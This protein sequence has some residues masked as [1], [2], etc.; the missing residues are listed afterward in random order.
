MLK[1]YR[2]QC[3]NAVFFRNSICLI[4]KSP[5]GFDAT[6][7]LL[8]PLKRSIR[9][10]NSEIW[11]Q[12]GEVDTAENLLDKQYRRCANLQTP[13]ACNWLL[14]S[15][16]PD[17]KIYCLACSLNRTIPD[18]TDASHPENS[19]YWGRVELAKRRMLAGLMGLGLT[20]T[21]KVDDPVGGLAFDLVNTQPGANPV[22]TG[23]DNGLITLNLQEADDAFRESIRTSM[24]EPYRTLLG[25]FRH[26]IGHYF[27]DVLIKNSAW[28]SKFRLLFGDESQDYTSSLQNNYAFGPPKD[29]FLNHVSSYA[30]SHPWEDWAETW[31]HYL[32]MCDT[33]DTA[34]SLGLAVNTQLL[35]FT[36]FKL[37]ALYDTQEENSDTFLVFINEWAGLTVLLN[38]MNR[39]MGQ[40]DFYPF[41]LPDTVVTKLHFIHLV[42]RSANE[43]LNKNSEIM[44]LESI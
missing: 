23:H 37:D 4:C 38:E 32:H 1:R 11:E 30:S 10:L 25:H 16:E 5:L 29:W 15:T 13:A 28:L 12:F 20:I 35:E 26:E 24:G 33:C 6:L 19:V 14:D 39:T 2:C 7:G 42:V 22:L 27:W 9:N 44:Q 43:S 34:T 36:P 21:T 31:A 18:L 41:V 8:I 3:G 17:V 40:S